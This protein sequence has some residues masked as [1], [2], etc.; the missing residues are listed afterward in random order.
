MISSVMPSLKWLSAPS[1]LR[2]PNG[3]TATVG[4][5]DA[6]VGGFLGSSGAGCPIGRTENTRMPPS[7]F[8]TSCWPKSVHVSDNGRAA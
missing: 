8:L 4:L 5:S 3:S 1:P 7:M 2:F 6:I